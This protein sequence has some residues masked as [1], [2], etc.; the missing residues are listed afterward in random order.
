MLAEEVGSWA[1]QKHEYLVRYLDI[2]RGVRK[3][4]VGPDKGGTTYIDLFCGPGR[5]VVRK[6]GEFIDGSCVAAWKKSV[7]G[8]APFSKVHIADSDEERLHL[9]EKR[10]RALGAPVVTHLGRATDTVKVIVKQVNAYGLHFAFVDPF[11]LGAFDFAIVNE[12]ARLKRIDMLV[13]VSKMDLQRNLGMNIRDQQTAF[14]SFAPGWKEGIDLTQ[15]QSKIRR[16]VFEYWRG[17]VSKSGIATSDH[18]D[19][20]LIT[21][22]KNQPLYW[23]LLAAKHELAHRFWKTASVSDQPSFL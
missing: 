9:A 17:L 6:S 10:L 16:H 3:N 14:N 2:S 18:V 5:A 22:S 4:F 21:G 7:E 20:K 8:G 1:K 19:M 13:H 11:N 15:A 23:L 12:L